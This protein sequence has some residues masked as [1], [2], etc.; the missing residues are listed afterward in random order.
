MCI[1][2]DDTWFNTLGPSFRFRRMA[3]E[4]RLVPCLTAGRLHQK[5][6]YI[7]R[8]SSHRTDS[9]GVFPKHLRTGLPETRF[10]SGIFTKPV[11]DRL[12]LSLSWGQLLLDE[13]H[14]T[15]EGCVRPFHR[16][17]CSKP[18][19][20]SHRISV[21]H[22]VSA[23]RRQLHAASPKIGTRDEACWLVLI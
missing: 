15:F 9:F 19:M 10:D 3:S 21:L 2:P 7:V 14:R 5:T 4:S 13:P 16:Y 11:P 8:H 17:F 6:P 1:S 23:G 22:R 12:L 20:R 18:N